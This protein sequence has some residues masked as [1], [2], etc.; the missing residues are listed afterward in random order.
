MAL[1]LTKHRFSLAKFSRFQFVP[2]VLAYPLPQTGCGIPYV[3]LLP[4]PPR[5]CATFLTGLRLLPSSPRTWSTPT[6]LTCVLRFS[7]YGAVFARAHSCTRISLSP[8]Q[9]YVPRS[10]KPYI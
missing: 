2:V 8:R 9:R 1:V 4:P 6:R 7:S 3:L 10:Y 5:C